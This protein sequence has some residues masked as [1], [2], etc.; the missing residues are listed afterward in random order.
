[1]GR[2]FEKNVL[3]FLFV[4]GLISFFNLVR[5]PPVKDSLIIFFLKSYIASLLD[6]LTVK[7]GYVKYPV[8]LF[9]TF[10]ISVL[11]SYLLF[12][13]TCVYYNQITKNSNIF[14][15]I[16]KVIYFSVPMTLVET[17]LEKNTKL[18][19]Y[20]KGWDWK[21]SFASI[22]GTFLIVRLLMYVINRAA[23]AK[24]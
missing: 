15:V 14:G 12:P 24:D 2:T 9:K 13:I 8:N 7:K 23:A 4:F 17:W 20:K 6:T 22:S 16:L 10:N 5:K 11:F 18:I 19:K 21:H 1:M 3:R